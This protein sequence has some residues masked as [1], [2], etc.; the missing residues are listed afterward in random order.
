[1][2]FTYDDTYFWVDAPNRIRCLTEHD[3]KYA[4]YYNPLSDQ[5]IQYEMYHLAE[6]PLESRNL[7]HPQYYRPEIEPERRRLHHKLT[8]LMEELGT[9]P[10]E[11][12]WPAAA[13]FDPEVS[14]PDSGAA[15]TDD[16]EAEEETSS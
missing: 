4:L 16:D 14:Y 9:T 15:D 13:D 8:A 1:V 3:W 11:I 7:T 10:G 12:I 6:D 2:H 5:A